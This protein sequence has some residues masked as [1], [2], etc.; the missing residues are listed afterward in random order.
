MARQPDL[1]DLDREIRDH[2]DAETQDNIARG[3]C[4]DEARAAAIRKF[5]NIA[6]VKED[7]RGVWVPGWIDRLRQDAR[8]ATRYLRRNPGFSFAIVVT[9]ALG[10][11]LTTT[12]YSVVNAV[13]LRPLAYAHPERMVWLATREARSNNEM[14]N[15]IDFA[16][17]QSQVTSLEHMI[18]Y[19]YS[20]ST[21]VAGGEASRVQIVSASDGFFEVTGA[22]ALFGT[23]PGPND[24]TVLV[25]AHR[26]FSE[27]FHGD[28]GVIGRAIS[29]DGRE[30]T[31]GGVLPADF[32]PQL[33]AH[34]FGPAVERVDPAA[35]RMMQLQAPPREITPTTQ[36]R[37]YQSMAE[38]KPGVSIDQA[39]A[40]IDA[41]HAR[42]QQDHPS[43]F[44]TTAAV[45]TPLRDKLVGPSRP[46]LRV[47]M[48]ASLF[49]LLITCA[50]V[51][52]LLLS[53][54]AARRKE[55]ALRM[56]VGSGP[57]RVIRQLLAESLA[58]AMI[59]GLSGVVLASWMVNVVVGVIG[60][61]V[62]RLT[63]TTLDRR[64]MGVAIAISI[65]TALLF[66]VGPAI[67]LC[68]TN[69]QEVL[70]EGGR[71][72]SASRR[73]LLT[74][75]AMVA[76][77]L[78]LTVVLLAGAGLMFKSV[79]QMTRYPAGFTPDQI[80]TMRLDFRGPQYR[81]QPARHDLAA[82]LLAKAKSLPGVRTAAITTGA[83]SMTLVLK[84][85]ESIPPPNERSSKEAML[86]SISADFGPLLGMSL[87][88]GRWFQEVEP[89]G[90]I[91]L[92]E[93]LA[94]RE[95][96]NG[97][98]LNGRIRMPWFRDD[99]YGTVVG[100]VADL[101]YA[102]IDKDPFPEVFYHHA[103]AP[104]FGITL[105]MRIDGDPSAAAP[106][107]RK[108][109]S[110]IDPTQS[111]YDVRTMEQALSESIAPRRFN[112]LLLGTFALVALVL[113]VLGVYGVVA[114]A[115]AERTQE[116]GIRLALGAERSRVVRIIVQQGMLSV[117]AGLIAGVIGAIG[118]T[119]LIAGLLYG[120]AAHDVPTFVVATISLA[121]IALLACTIPALKAATVDPVA[122]LRAE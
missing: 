89:A 55:I 81:E 58:Y 19:D 71:S 33:A 51:A 92:N 65:G 10:I 62:P 9:L 98:A 24:T 63:E 13:L 12:I 6:R 49:V 104:L 18:A 66:G 120:V 88:K 35:Y 67:A 76:I 85:G 74:G 84:E 77:Q 93:T 17:W 16:N 115:V 53:R 116:I 38:L 117:T 31:I 73:V 112:L 109:L 3:M 50:N 100:V 75:R 80:L 106:G 28:K 118:A 4:E 102:A 96:P 113:A 111:F 107:I 82:A 1:D 7:V 34:T 15:S 41:I 78:A 44:G 20:D 22:K 83:D 64:V 86:S 14:M 108:A 39:R 54:S 47:L 87:V 2:I 68:F 101:K 40:E 119:R 36:V 42:E 91:L 60:P 57:L 103:D 48:A 56:S 29:V 59:G 27:Q 97:D 95:F 30:L 37:L 8:D 79:W 61:A 90:A 11:G 114:Y 43:M 110:T 99:R 5:G 52:N 21:L 26:T 121:A 45:V 105:T 122:A 70:K 46:A 69:V 94:R 23:L 72:V 25:L 32:A